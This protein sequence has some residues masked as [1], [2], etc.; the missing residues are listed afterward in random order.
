MCQQDLARLVAGKPGYPVI[1]VPVRRPLVL[2]LAP[3]LLLFAAC[4]GGPAPRQYDLTGQILAV[5][6]DGRELVV[7]HD[8]VKGFM[9]A[10]TMPFRLKDPALAR[11]RRPGDLIRATLMVTD[12]ESW[13][14]GI[15]KTGWAPLPEDDGSNRPAIE[16]VKP[17]DPVPDETLVDQDGKAFRISSL[18]GSAVLVTFIY[19]RCPLPE[20]CPRMDA[21]FAAVQEALAGGRLGGPVRLLSVS[22]DPDFDTPAV[23]KAHAVSVGADPR[24]WRFATAPTDRVEAWG[25]RL[26][27][28]VIRD[29]KDPSDLTHNL[30]TAVI[31]ARGRLVT[32]LDGNR[33]TVDEA[34]TAL[35]SAGR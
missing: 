19:T 8:V 14:A 25:G 5:S 24:V 20:F 2:T 6:P 28:S 16:L 15:E 9:P 13:L 12:E 32:I 7:R 21:Y 10:M 26:G 29:P 33:W 18:R 35:G 22:F 23:L 3:F 4:A 1:M 34:V 11:D 31:D 30:R 27:L 17:G